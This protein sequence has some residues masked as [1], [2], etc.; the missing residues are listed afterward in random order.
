MDNTVRGLQLESHLGRASVDNKQEW[1]LLVRNWFQNP[2]IDAKRRKEHRKIDNFQ[3]PRVLFD[4][5]PSWSWL[6]QTFVG[7][8]IIGA[9]SSSFCLKI[10]HPHPCHVI[11][12]KFHTLFLWAWL[13]DVLGQWDVS[14]CEANGGLSYDCSFDLP[15]TSIICHDKSIQQIISDRRRIRGI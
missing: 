11:M 3:Y 10:G 13:C 14:G 7:N 6:H 5:V 15:L 8:W 4:I 1:V 2:R 12:V 9:N